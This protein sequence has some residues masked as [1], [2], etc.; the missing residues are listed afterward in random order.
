MRS[1]RT[2]AGAGKYR[3]GM[4]KRAARPLQPQGP[5][6]RT[7]ILEA[8]LEVF[9]AHGF[10]A[11]TT[12]AI[13][14][15]AHVTQPLVHYHF[16]T[17]E[18]LWEATIAALF[19][20]MRAAFDE[21]DRDLRDADPLTRLKAFV[22]RYVRF[23]GEHPAA[24]RLMHNIGEHGDAELDRLY[25]TYLQPI[26]DRLGGAVRA[27]QDAGYLK[28][29]P[30][31]EVL[32]VVVGAAGHV[33]GRAAVYNRQSGVDVLSREYIEAHADAVIDILFGGLELGQ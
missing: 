7:A 13:A 27:A 25:E 17:K 22:R 31:Q 29:I 8:A 18:R 9:S 19:E 12:S 32:I 10:E 2:A 11:A 20:P 4:A 21:I 23:A 14:R 24:T 26:Q 6:G 30:V 28:P 16:G 3:P 33:F 15:A 5:D 1:G